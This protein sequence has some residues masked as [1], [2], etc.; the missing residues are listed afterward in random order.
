MQGKVGLLIAY[1][2]QIR[3]VNGLRKRRRYVDS[4]DIQMEEDEEKRR[5]TMAVVYDE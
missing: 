5:R 1:R 3:K 4:E 2:R